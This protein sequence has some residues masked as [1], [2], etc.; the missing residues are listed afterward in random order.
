MHSGHFDD[1]HDFAGPLA[2]VDGR[3]P[4][5]AFPRLCNEFEVHEKLFPAFQ[6]I[7]QLRHEFLDIFE[8]QVD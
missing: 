4:G 5:C 2:D 8:V 7:F 1:N 6:E 3:A